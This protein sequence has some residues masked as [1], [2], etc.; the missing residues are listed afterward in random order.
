VVYLFVPRNILKKQ[1]NLKDLFIIIIFILLGIIISLFKGYGDDLDSHSLILSFIRIYEN[2]VYSP[3]RFQGSPVAEIF[4]GFLGYNFGSFPGSFL[5]YIFFISSLIVFFKSFKSLEF[6][7][8]TL[9]LFI[10][11]CISNPILFLDNTNPSDYPMSLFFFAFGIYYFK[12]N[13]ILLPIIFFSLTVGT[14]VEFIL[15]T[16]CYLIYEIYK[17]NYNLKNI[18]KIITFTLLLSFFFYVPVLIKYEF[19]PYLIIFSA[20]AGLKFYELIPRFIFKFYLS[21]G[22]FSSFI[23]FLIV[24]TNIN[25]LKKVIKQNLDLLILIF[26][27][28]LVFLF[29]PIKTSILSLTIIFIYI[30]LFKIVKK[31]IYIFSLIFFNFI[32]YL[33]SYEV[34]EIQYKNSG[35]CDPI[36]AVDAKFKFNIDQGYL[37]KRTKFMKNQIECASYYFGLKS[38]KY[39]DGKKIK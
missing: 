8:E 20:D 33:I 21:L 29:M 38:Q 25:E 23:I 24:Y 34:L 17:D 31:R 16:L 35:K 36:I 30:L 27:N 5:S 22:V 39:I 12:R 10:I 2:G 7:K 26:L 3:S 32:S 18:L 14:R 9:L 1:L 13:K 6:N 15:F 37:T 4:Y 19:S 28:S 11:V